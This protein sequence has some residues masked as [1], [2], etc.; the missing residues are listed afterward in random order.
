M[1]SPHV[2]FLILVNGSWIEVDALIKNPKPLL[3]YYAQ[4]KNCCA[5]RGGF[6]IEADGKPWN[7]RTTIDEFDMTEEWLPA[8]AAALRDPSEKAI[9]ARVWEE[10]SLLIKR[11]GDTIELEDKALADFKLCQK[12]SFPIEKFAVEMIRE[13]KKASQLMK[14]LDAIPDSDYVAQPQDWAES[15]RSLPDWHSLVGNLERALDEYR[16]KSL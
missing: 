12:I 1:S 3:E 9:D 10:S 5:H 2:T 16:A 14:T 11:I 6:L 13:A 4:E 15:Y 8:L 7:D